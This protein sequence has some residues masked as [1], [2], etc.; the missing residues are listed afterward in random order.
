MQPSFS[1][2]SA[3]RAKQ[4]RALLPQPGG[5]EGFVPGSETEDRSDDPSLAELVEVELVD[6]DRDPARLALPLPMRRADHGVGALD[7]FLDVNAQF[8]EGG[9]PQVQG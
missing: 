8:V 4:R 9:G 2:T 3:F 1:G 5:F 7:V 6:I